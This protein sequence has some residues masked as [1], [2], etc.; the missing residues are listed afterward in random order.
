MIR[1]SGSNCAALS[2]DSMVAF[3]ARLFLDGL[4]VPNTFN[5]SSAGCKRLL[6]P[7]SILRTLPQRIERLGHLHDRRIN[8]WSNGLWRFMGNPA[9]SP[10]ALV[11]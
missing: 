3:G 1:R 9:T 7:S 8:D 2:Y 5:W 11:G 6:S 4:G 10:G